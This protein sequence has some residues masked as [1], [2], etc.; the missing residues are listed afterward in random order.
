MKDHFN[1]L[2]YVL[3]HK[4]YVLKACFMVDAPLWLGIIHDLS[5]FTPTE[6]TPYVHTFYKPDGTRQCVET[7]EFK[8]A[9]NSHQKKNKHHWQYWVLRMDDGETIALEM[10]EKYVLEMVADWCG[11]GMAITGKMEVWN[12]FEKNKDKMI[13]HPKTKSRVTSLITTLKV[14]FSAS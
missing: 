2:K 3:R 6:W 5:K 14:R 8:F 10:P 4:W 9:W 11:A 13:L 12:W 7:D 1:Y